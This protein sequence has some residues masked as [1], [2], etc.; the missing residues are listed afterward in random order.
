VGYLTRMIEDLLVLARVDTG[1]RAL[2][3]SSVA[4]DETLVDVVARLNRIAATKHVDLMLDVRESSNY[5]VQGD[6]DL[7][8]SLFESIVENA[9]KYSPPQG[10]RVQ[11]RLEE[12]P[13]TV[14]V[15]IT[16]Q[17]VGITKEDL[18]K[19]FDRFYR[20]DRTSNQQPGSGLGLAIAKRIIEAHQASIRA[21]SE[22]G[23]G[24]SIQVSLRK[25]LIA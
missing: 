7:I 22:P 4:L 16:A 12:K 5:A 15:A 3:L 1:S 10:G 24:T 13:D 17:G 21:E 8:R 19:I 2:S 6:Q 23:A 18:P 11:I 14:D 9:I 20:S 25:K